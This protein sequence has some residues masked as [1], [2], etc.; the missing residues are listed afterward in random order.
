V[1]G[2]ELDPHC[3]LTLKRVQHADIIVLYKELPHSDLVERAE[4]LLTLM[5]TPF[6]VKF[7]RQ[8]HCTIAVR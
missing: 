1:I 3:Y 7:I 4:D 2:V 6:A 8:C 5:R